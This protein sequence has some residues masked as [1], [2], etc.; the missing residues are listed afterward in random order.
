MPLRHARRSLT[1]YAA[2]SL[3]FSVALRFADISG[4]NVS[5]S[6]PHTTANLSRKLKSLAT[7][8]AFVDR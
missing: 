4:V 6:P 1:Y 3:L 2:A 5:Q 8:N 7:L